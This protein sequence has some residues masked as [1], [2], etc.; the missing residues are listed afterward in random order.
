M[1]Y[2]HILFKVILFVWL[3]LC[4]LQDIRRQEI[5]LM[6]IAGGFALLLIV[7]L[8]QGELSIWERITGA[9]LGL[10]IIL[11]YKATR[12]QIGLG[13]GLILSITGISLGFYINVV[14]VIYSLLFSAIFSILYILIKKASKKTTIP[15]VPFVFIASWGI[16][17]N[18]KYL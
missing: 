4:S 9:S 12:G 11:L 1:E 2:I 17:F 3:L 16:I 14:L 15:F 10:V 6:L 8:V 13:D 5:S 7:S 18:E